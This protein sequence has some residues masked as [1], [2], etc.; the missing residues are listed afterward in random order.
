MK[1]LVNPPRRVTV[2]RNIQTQR[3]TK[4][5]QGENKGKKMLNMSTGEFCNIEYANCA[6]ALTHLHR[7]DLT[8]QLLFQSDLTCS[9]LPTS[10]Y[11]LIVSSHNSNNKL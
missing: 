10:E 1:A 3:A 6:I 11:H 9:S 8:N 4:K 7:R 5:P 2:V